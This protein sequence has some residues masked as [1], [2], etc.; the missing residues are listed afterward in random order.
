MKGTAKDSDGMDYTWSAERYPGRSSNRRIIDFTPMSYA[1]F[2]SG[3]T[4]PVLRI[5][6]GDTV[7]TSSIDAGGID[8]SGKRVS[9][10]GNPLT[11]PFYVVG[12]L[13]GDTLVVKLKRITLNRDW[14][15]SGTE[16]VSN[17]VAPEYTAGMHRGKGLTG[18]WHLDAK[19]GTA[20]IQGGSD[21]VKALRVPLQPMLGGIGV[22]PPMQEVSNT[23]ASGSFGGNMDYSRLR[24]GTTVYL[25]VYQ[26]GALLLLGDA[27]AAEG[28]GEL[29]GDALETS[30]DFEFTVDVIPNFSLDMPCAD[31]GDSWM[32]IGIAG[33]LEEALR[34]STTAMATYL[35]KEHGLNS[36]EAAMLLGAAMKY[37]VAD[38]VGDQVSIV[39][40]LPKSLIAQL[41]PGKNLF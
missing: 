11:G 25:P 34:R 38:V 17:A 4:P 32:V 7:R 8:A 15:Q 18:R 16:I 41:P 9:R 1:R 19:S 30:M 6:A 23:R 12:A 39:A 28:D 20:S 3:L 14:A 10:G 29:A 35:E 24:K 31:D 13:P 27:H 37:D 5:S 2:F 22:A 26:P 33:S 36:N 21:A 40:R